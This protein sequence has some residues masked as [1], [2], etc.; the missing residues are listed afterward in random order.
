MSYHT[1]SGTIDASGC[2]ASGAVA[3][4]LAEVDP[5]DLDEEQINEINEAIDEWAERDPGG[6]SDYEADRLDRAVASILRRTRP[7]VGSVIDAVGHL[8]HGLEEHLRE[9]GSFLVSWE[10]E[11]D[12][13][14]ELVDDVVTEINELLPFGWRAD[15]TG[16]AN[17][18]EEDFEIYLL[19]RA[20]IGGWEVVAS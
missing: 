19:D 4:W 3:E 11:Y 20:S 15:W 10:T 12:E 13:C 9:D 5:R 2:L 1:R 8:F 17:G 7:G 18:A 14:G 16:D 6:Y